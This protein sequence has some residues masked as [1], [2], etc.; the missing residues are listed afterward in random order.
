[1]LITV[2]LYVLVQLTRKKIF[3]VFSSDKPN[4]G[5]GAKAGSSAGIAKLFP[6]FFSRLLQRAEGGGR[7]FGAWLERRWLGEQKIL[8]M[9]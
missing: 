8:Q 2:D 4:R 3:L 6:T 5:W 9:Y 7:A 1:M